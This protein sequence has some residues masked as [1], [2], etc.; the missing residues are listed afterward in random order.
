MSRYGG[1]SYSGV[2]DDYRVRRRSSSRPREE[3][4][5]YYGHR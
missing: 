4:N 2:Y 5:V 3:S 1:E